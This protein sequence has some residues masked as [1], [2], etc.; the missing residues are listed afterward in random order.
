MSH[1]SLLLAVQLK[2]SEAISSLSID[3]QVSVLEAMLLLIKPKGGR[4]QVENKKSSSKDEKSANPFKSP[5]APIQPKPIPVKEVQNFL[6]ETLS[7]LSGFGLPEPVR[8]PNSKAPDI[9]PRKI[10]DRLSDKRA[11]WNACLMSIRDSLSKGKSASTESLALALANAL[12]RFRLELI[13]AKR[14][15]I[16]LPTLLVK[17]E[18]NEICYV[19]GV[20]A[21]SCIASTTGYFSFIRERNPAIDSEDLVVSD[22]F[23][24]IKNQDFFVIQDF[25]GRPA[26]Q[27][28][29]N[30]L[31]VRAKAHLAS[32]SLD[33]RG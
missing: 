8:D 12:Q 4:S 7:H 21:E 14:E 18:E 5:A 33:T 1:Y 30:S 3:D 25:A 13:L 2:L 26:P 15:N 11:E 19:L 16:T 27:P 9:T 29:I 10:R 23:Y 6:D 24:G 17:A 32:S 22:P 31:A 20:L 28:A